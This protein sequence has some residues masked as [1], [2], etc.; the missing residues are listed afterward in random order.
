MVKNE[1]RKFRNSKF[2]LNDNFVNIQSQISQFLRFKM[3]TLF[4]KG[5]NFCTKFDPLN[6]FFKRRAFIILKRRNWKICEH[7]SFSNYRNYPLS[8]SMAL[9]SVSIAKMA[10]WVVESFF[11]R[12]LKNSVNSSSSVNIFPGILKIFWK[13]KINFFTFFAWAV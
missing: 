12:S 10:V 3:M 5:P 2:D 11:I 7:S 8:T 4:L 9:F 1:N 6:D 13:K